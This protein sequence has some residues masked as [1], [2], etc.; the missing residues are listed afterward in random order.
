MVAVAMDPGRRKDRG[1]AVQKLESGEAQG[2]AAGGIGFR[3]EVEDLVGASADEVE[4]VECK[5]RPGTIPDQPFQ[6]LP[7]G[8]LD[9]DAGVETEPTAV[10]PP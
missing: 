6:A 9:T 10:I 8:G 2:G 1:Q 3:Q 4:P 7:V 5:G